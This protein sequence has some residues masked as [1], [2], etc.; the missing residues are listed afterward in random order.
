[1]NQDLFS[2]TEQIAA[3]YSEHAL[4]V[5]YSGGVDSHVLLHLLASSD[6]IGLSRL[7]AI[8]ID[9]C[10]QADSE[11]WARH[12]EQVASG[13]NVDFHCVRVAV[14]DIPKLGLEAA[15]RSVRYQAIADNVPAGGVVLTAQH[16]EDQAETFLLQLLRGAGVKGLSGMAADFMHE[17]KQVLRPL[18][19]ISQS[20]IVAYAEEHGLAWVEDPSNADTGFNR[21]YLRRRV[22]PLLEARW[23]SA[24]KSLSRSATYCAEADALLSELASIDFL[25]MGVDLSE[26]VIPVT[27]LLD[28]SPARARNLIRYV[29]GEL[30]LAMPSAI[31]L[32]RILAEVCLAAEDRVPMVSWA[33]IEARRYRDTLYFLSP[34]IEQDPTEYHLCNEPDDMLLSDGRALTWLEVDKVGISEALF[35]QGLKLGFRQG[36][37]TIQLVGHAH[38]KSLKQLYQEWAIP[39]WEREHIPLLFCGDTLLA[40]IGYGFSEQCTLLLGQ[41]GYFPLIEVV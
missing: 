29:L 36:G 17:G 40:V 28:L 1:V 13:L 22:W 12:C 23:P 4:W 31:I 27:A 11:H 33:N 24:A 8:H 32:Q 2:I 9:H 10:L 18:L 20:E 16:Q 41:K 34:Q 3:H 30:G 37:E 39:P 5:A 25:T 7:H 19:A 26:R 6:L 35:E 15:A 21:N 14:D 38:H